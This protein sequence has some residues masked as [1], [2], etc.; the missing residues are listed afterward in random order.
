MIWGPISIKLN[1]RLNLNKRLIGDYMKALSLIISIGFMLT[2]TQATEINEKILQKWAK[3]ESF[4]TQRAHLLELSSS[5][6]KNQFQ[7]K[8]SYNLSLQSKYK[9]TK[10]ISFSPSMPV[11]SPLK[12]NRITISKPTMYGAQTSLSAYTT[13]SSNSFYQKGTTTGVGLGLNIDLYKNLAGKVSKAQNES[14]KV[15]ALISQK[16][17]DITVHSFVQE[18]RKLYWRLV[19][20]NESL[21]IANALLKSA[22]RLEKDTLKRVRNNVADKGDLARVRSQV[23]S[24]KGKIYNL[25]FQKT[26]ILQKLQELFPTK[27][28]EKEIS[29][30]AYNINNTVQKV[31]SCSAIINSKQ[32]IPK[33]FTQYDEILSLLNKDLALSEKVNNSYDKMDIKL[34]SEF[35]YIGKAVNGF[36]NSLDNFKD[37]KRQSIQV[38]FQINIPLGN[39]KK[40]TKNIQEK[41]IRKQNIAKYREIEGKLQAFHHQTVESINI[42][43]KVLDAQKRNSI[44]LKETLKSANKKFRQARISSRDLISDEENYLQ[45]SLSEIQ[46]K[47]NVIETIINYFSVFSQTPCELN[48]TI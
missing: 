35:N 4:T 37:D 7:D 42:L 43:Y 45:S 46:I 32:S 41:I 26:K 10:E 33:D 47:Y 12:E 1:V 31:L 9:K 25:E 16:E 19:A 23:E 8:F 17:K 14:F 11:N 34:A 18:T 21:K 40:D 3:E 24:R 29:L 20:N 5:A 15:K 44:L 30:K 48:K 22:I 36:S 2:N 13:E 38:G 6:Q 39:K 27:L 28:P